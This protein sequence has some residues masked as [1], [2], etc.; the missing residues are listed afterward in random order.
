MYLQIYSSLGVIGLKGGQRFVMT[1]VL[2]EF[3]EAYFTGMWR[4]LWGQDGLT[5]HNA[6]LSLRV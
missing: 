6:P 5:V 2:I 3:D 4:G 1:I